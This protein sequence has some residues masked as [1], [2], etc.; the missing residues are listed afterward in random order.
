MI[1]SAGYV[2]SFASERCQADIVSYFNRGSRT[3]MK[4]DR[5][6]KFI[7]LVYRCSVRQLPIKNHDFSRLHR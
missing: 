1:G 7:C 3:V 6:T 4:L 5:P 2:L